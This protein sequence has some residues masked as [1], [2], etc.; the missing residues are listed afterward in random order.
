MSD[1]FKSLHNGAF[2]ETIEIP[3]HSYDTDDQE[4]VIFHMAQRELYEIVATS[5][6]VYY[7]PT[8][9]LTV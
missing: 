2:V 8:L 9:R 1:K 3:V 5:V 7:P 4:E 6:E